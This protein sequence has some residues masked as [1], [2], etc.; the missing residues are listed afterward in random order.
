MPSAR[1]LKGI[2]FPNHVTM[3]DVYLG[4]WCSFLKMSCVNGMLFSDCVQVLV[5]YFSREKLT[6]W[7]WIWLVF[8]IDIYCD[9]CVLCWYCSRAVE[10]VT[11]YLMRCKWKLT[12]FS[13]AL[14][15][16]ARQSMLKLEWLWETMH[17]GTI[18]VLLLSFNDN[19]WEK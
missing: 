9:V 13:F 19:L 1:I 14:Q 18:R 6:K 3:K 7:K 16:V 4:E 15:K 11:S 17:R 12:V 10:V 5:G 8:Q 2:W